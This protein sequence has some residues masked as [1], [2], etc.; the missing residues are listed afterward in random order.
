MEGFLTVCMAEVWPNLEDNVVVYS[1]WK[2]KLASQ[3]APPPAPV[4]AE[5]ALP[6]TKSTVRQQAF[7]FD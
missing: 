6:R 5:W 1:W 3:G 2:D 7:G 4:E